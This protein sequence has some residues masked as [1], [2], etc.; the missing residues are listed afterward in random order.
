MF[1]INNNSNSATSQKKKNSLVCTLSKGV[2]YHKYCTFLFLIKQPN[3][4]KKTKE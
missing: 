1:A 3:L 4:L 2:L